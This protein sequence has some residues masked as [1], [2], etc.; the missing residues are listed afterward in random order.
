MA[1]GDRTRLWVS[2]LEQLTCVQRL[3][4]LTALP[5]ASAISC[6][7]LL[8]PCRAWCSLCY[9]S[10][11]SS[12]QPVY[13]ALLWAFQI[14]TVCP[15]HR[16]QL[17]TVCPFCGRT[18]YVFSSKARPGHCSRC[19]SWLGREPKATPFG[20]DIGAQI[21]VAEM[22]GEL[23]AASASFPAGVTLDVFRENVR[24]HA[25]KAGGAVRFHAAIH[26]PYI[27]GWTRRANVPRL[28]SLVEL[29][30]SLNVSVVR[31]L[32]ERIDGGK[33]PDQKR[34]SQTQPRVAGSIVEK[35]LQTALQSD[36][37]PPLKEIA[38]QLGYRTA[39][40]LQSRYPVLCSE[41]ATRRLSGL[42][43]YRTRSPVTPVPRDRIEKALIRELSEP[44]FTDL[45]AVAASVG[46]SSKRRLYKDFRELR[47][48]I[49]VKNAQFKN[50]R[51]RSCGDSTLRAV[52]DGAL[53]A[54]FDERPIP[55]VTEVARRLGFAAVRPVTS[56]FPEL[57]AEL[58]SCRHRLGTTRCRD[59]II[60]RVR[61][62]LS[63]ALA[64][65]PPPSC[66]EIVSSLA[67]HRTQIREDFPDLWSALR[68]RYVEHKQQAHH[69]KRQ[70]F[71]DDVLRAVAELHRKGLYPTVQLVLASIPAPRFRSVDIV[72]EA[73]HL[74]RRKL[75]IEP[76]LNRRGHA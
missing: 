39:A 49:V 76:Y 66:S 74:A 48:A 5:W 7:H 57:T 29:S 13:E 37:P 10:R 52:I 22:V 20:T 21:R 45:K 17:D 54:A 23:L 25:Q 55:T 58:R 28:D 11:R 59:Q 30:R 4:L 42:K 43:A 14:V 71:A 8:R 60:E 18:Q 61:Q 73:V 34:V 12:E 40:S 68:K 35:A 32:T 24:R 26:H 2:L 53:R 31:L 50:R 15:E 47:M 19:Q 72:A 62:R 67:G 1:S 9:E 70:A 56:R 51:G 33:D 64:E 63:E 3:D 27:R 6:V 38:N 65:S 41:V 16:R 75:S 46:L 36:I 69:S 44:G